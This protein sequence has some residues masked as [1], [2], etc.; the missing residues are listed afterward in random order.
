MDQLV[1]VF[2]RKYLLL[3]K[4]QPFSHEDEIITQNDILGNC[5]EREWL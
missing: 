5:N 2:M 3:M 4:S 1:K